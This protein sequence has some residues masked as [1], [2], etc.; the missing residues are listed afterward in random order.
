MRDFARFETIPRLVL[1]CAS[2]KVIKN[3]LFTNIIKTM[4][5]T[6]FTMSS[7]Q[8]PAFHCLLTAVLI[9]AVEAVS[10]SASSFE[11]EF[12]FSRNRENYLPSFPV[13]YNGKW[14]ETYLT[15]DGK[16]CLFD[17]RSPCIIDNH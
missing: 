2:C 16:T 5:F 9:S 6:T 11:G 1:P 10:L 13:K 8:L 12:K 4:H 14:L 15:I 7:H 17:L 3:N